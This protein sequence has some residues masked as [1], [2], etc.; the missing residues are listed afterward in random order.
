[1]SDVFDSGGF[2]DINSQADVQI[3]LR[4]PAA[5][6]AFPARLLKRRAAAEPGKAAEGIRHRTLRRKAPRRAIPGP[7]SE[8]HPVRR[9]QGRRKGICR[10]AR[11]RQGAEQEGLHHRPGPGDA[12]RGRVPQRLP[13][14]GGG[15]PG[16]PL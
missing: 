3:L 12:Q 2:H 1:M 8:R 11:G 5:V 6:L 13:L 9:H 4:D 10:H 15:E 14:R 16:A 7:W